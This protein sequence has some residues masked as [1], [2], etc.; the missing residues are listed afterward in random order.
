M[1]Y[2]ESFHSY[3]TELWPKS[4]GT[5]SLEIS[6]CPC[7]LTPK[8]LW[9]PYMK[10]CECNKFFDFLK[11]FENTELTTHALDQVHCWDANFRLQIGHYENFTPLNFQPLLFSKQWWL[12]DRRCTLEPL[13]AKKIMYKV[14]YS[15]KAV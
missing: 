1:S 7:I 4:Y 15:L 13:V 2:K 12:T 3:K 11:L 14:P 10:F 6:K 8:G 5:F 9:V